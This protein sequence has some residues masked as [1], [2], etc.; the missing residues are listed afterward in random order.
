MSS[1]KRRAK[2]KIAQIVRMDQTRQRMPPSSSFL[3]V[4][5][6]DKQYRFFEACMCPLGKKLRR[7]GLMERTKA[8]LEAAGTNLRNRGD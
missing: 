1:A 6:R 4:F 3:A 2:R 5:G 8:A 7:M